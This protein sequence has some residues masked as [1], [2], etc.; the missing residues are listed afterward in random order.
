MSS[1][2]LCAVVVVGEFAIIQL[3]LTVIQSYAFAELSRFHWCGHN[4]FLTS[5]KMRTRRR[6]QSAARKDNPLGR[7][8][9]QSVNLASSLVSF[10]RKEPHR[11]PSLSQL[12]LSNYPPVV[13]YFH[14][15][16][17]YNTIV[18]NASL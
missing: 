18:F 16:L 11:V 4:T 5:I 6:K 3:D 8:A 7:R 14:P 17:E 9:R 13:T 10:A 1:G 2:C 12:S 15:S